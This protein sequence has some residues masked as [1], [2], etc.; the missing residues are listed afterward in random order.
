MPSIKCCH[1][2]LR[3]VFLYHRKKS[4]MVLLV[5]VDGNC[6]QGGSLDVPECSFAVSSKGRHFGCPPLSILSATYCNT[7]VMVCDWT[8]FS[9]GSGAIFPTTSAPSQKQTNR[10]LPHGRTHQGRGSNRHF[11]QRILLMQRDHTFIFESLLTWLLGGNS[12]NTTPEAASLVSLVLV[13]NWF[14]GTAS[15]TRT[16]RWERGPRNLLDVIDR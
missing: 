5:H 14:V 4:L 12:T 7:A 1:F 11:F 15:V 2:L 8:C 16:R 9:I 10:S 3:W 13:K 6:T